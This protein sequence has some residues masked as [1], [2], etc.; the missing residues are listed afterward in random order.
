MWSSYNYP[1]HQFN[2]IFQEIVL[3]LSSLSALGPIGAA[4]EI[5]IILYPL[6][7]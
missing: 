4:M 1:S 5:I 3:G 6:L 2:C 7:Q